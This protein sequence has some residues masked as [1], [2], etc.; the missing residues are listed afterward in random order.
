MKLFS[1][2]KDNSYIIFK[3]L[4]NQV[5]MIMFGVVLGLAGSMSE[6]NTVLLV[7]GIA[8]TLFYWF[9]LYTLAWDYGSKEK[10]RVD[11]GRLAYQPCKGLYFSLAA[12]AIN[13]LVGILVAAFWF[14]AGPEA[15][16][17]GFFMKLGFLLNSMYVS[18]SGGI[19]MLYSEAVGAENLLAS[20]PLNPILYV[21]YPLPALGICTLG[22]YLGVHD[23]RLL[24]FSSGPKE[25]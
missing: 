8:S 14:G 23:R 12:N 5:G 3:E 9:L 13:I 4:A 22:Y 2:L 19:N 7:I 16:G 25:N 1:F 6:N 11:A 15:N 20:S 21:I 10:V 24:G 18:L 17:T